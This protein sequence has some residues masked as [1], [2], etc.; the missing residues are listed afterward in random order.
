MNCVPRQHYGLRRKRPLGPFPLNC[1]VLLQVGECMQLLPSAIEKGI[2][3]TAFY[4]N[5]NHMYGN[6]EY[7]NMCDKW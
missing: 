7:K 6:Y 4:L 2:N 1:Q 3:V 5:Q